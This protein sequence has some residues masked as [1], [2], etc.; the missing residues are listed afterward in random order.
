MCVI[1]RFL[2]MNIQMNWC[3]SKFL[4]RAFYLL[5]KT[6]SPHS[7][8]FSIFLRFSFV[9]CQ[10]GLTCSPHTLIWGKKVALNMWIVGHPDY[11]YEPSM[12]R[13]MWKLLNSCWSR[14]VS[15]SICMSPRVIWAW[16]QNISSHLVAQGPLSLLL[17]HFVLCISLGPRAF[18]L[19]SSSGIEMLLKSRCWHCLCRLYL[20]F[21]THMGW[22]QCPLLSFSRFVFTIFSV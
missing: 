8:C 13:F 16:R 19:I 21:P 15:F 1:T 11:Y 22:R 12:R 9:S 18:S 6:G 5:G 7:C 2:P 10:F 14:W 20:C 4:P 17:W 3:Q